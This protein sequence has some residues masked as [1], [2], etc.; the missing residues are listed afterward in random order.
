MEYKVDSDTTLLSFLLLQTSKKRSEL[1]NLLKFERI[2]VDGHIQTHYAYPLKKGQ[3]VSIGKKKDVLP[4]PIVYEDKDIIVI[5][6]PCG[7]LSEETA[8]ES[9]KTAYM[10]VKKYL[11]SHHENI[12][13]V[14]RLDQYTS[15]LLMFVKNKKLYDI[16]THHWDQYVK[17]RGYVAVVEGRMKKTHGT[18]DNYLAE[19]KTQNVYITNKQNGKRAIT[20]Y[21]VIRSNQKYSLLEIYLDTGRKNQIRV[22]LSS[23]HHPIVGDTKYQS[24]TNPLK[25]L[26]LHAHEFMFIHPFTQ[27]EMRFVSPTPQS[28]ERLFDTKKQ[29]IC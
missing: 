17:T 12:F 22:H 11:T 18:I 9:Q 28:F 24:T 20:H 14:H 1:K 25:R 19:S 23:L 29:K 21:R 5:D 16:L 6:K 4:F 13:L 26:G 7:L 8:K 10:I 2:Y 3:I 27:K 15:G